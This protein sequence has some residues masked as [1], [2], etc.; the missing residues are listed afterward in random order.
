MNA[1]RP[2]V[3]AHLR[4]GRD[5]YHHH[6][7]HCGRTAGGHVGAFL[8]PCA[9]EHDLAEAVAALQPQSFDGNKLCGRRR[10][11]DLIEMPPQHTGLEAASQRSETAPVPATPASRSC[12]PTGP[13]GWGGGKGGD[14]RGGCSKVPAQ[15]M[16][17]AIPACKALQSSKV[18]KSHSLCM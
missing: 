14:W 18:L 6:H 17:Q 8:P 10:V 12:T 7:H 2:A 3:Q 5:H 9:H 1:M 4:S 11:C 16:F 13:S 15:K